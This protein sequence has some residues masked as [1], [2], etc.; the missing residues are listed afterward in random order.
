[1]ALASVRKIPIFNARG[2]ARGPQMLIGD[3]MITAHCKIEITTAADQILEQMR[4][5]IIA[6]GEANNQFPGDIRRAV[7]AQTAMA[8]EWTNKVKDWCLAAKPGER[9]VYAEIMGDLLLMAQRLQ[10][11][12]IEYLAR[13]VARLADLGYCT[14]AFRRPQYLAIRSSAGIVPAAARGGVVSKSAS[15]VYSG[16]APGLDDHGSFVAPQ[17]EA[18]IGPLH[19]PRSE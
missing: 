19:L 15:P 3:A 18:L 6:A 13:Y 12:A 9:L 5:D 11:P 7:K 2:D 14:M 10:S 8:S 16:H 4:Q 17:R 1:M